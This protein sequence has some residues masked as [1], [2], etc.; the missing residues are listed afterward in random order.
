MVAIGFAALQ[1]SRYAAYYTY[2]MLS[3]LFS[4][5]DPACRLQCFW[6]FSQCQW[7]WI[8][9]HFPPAAKDWRVGHRQLFVYQLIRIFDGLKFSPIEVRAEKGWKLLPYFFPNIRFDLTFRGQWKL[10]TCKHW[11]HRFFV[12]IFYI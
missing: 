9:F 10:W 6:Q 7:I 2:A 5:S 11:L 3:D 4:P 12:F 1:L 8:I